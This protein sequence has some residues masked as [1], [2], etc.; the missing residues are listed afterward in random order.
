MATT[1]LTAIEKNGV[2]P[3]NFAMRLSRF[4]RL[5]GEFTE[6]VHQLGCVGLKTPRDKAK[7]TRASNVL[8]RHVR[9]RAEY[10]ERN[11]AR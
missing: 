8:K 1:P 7:L 9:E 11:V 6:R 3:R 4:D 5:I 10:L 2:N